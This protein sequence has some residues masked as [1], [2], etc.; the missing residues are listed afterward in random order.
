MYANRHFPSSASH[1]IVS[2]VVSRAGLSLLYD[3]QPYFTDL[4]LPGWAPQPD[5]QM[6]FGAAAA[7]LTDNHWIDDLRVRTGA[8]VDRTPVAVHLALNGQQFGAQAAVPYEYAFAD[9]VFP[10]PPPPRPWY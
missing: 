3:H 1:S 7:E 9:E 2:L 8:H 5:W 4:A 10:P 6:A